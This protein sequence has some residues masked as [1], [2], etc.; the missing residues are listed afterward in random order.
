[1][2]STLIYMTAY[3]ARGFELI[4][5]ILIH[6]AI[7]LFIKSWF[8]S[9]VFSIATTVTIA[10]AV[11]I[12]L[13]TD[14]LNKYNSTLFIIFLYGVIVFILWYLPYQFDSL[15]N[16]NKRLQEKLKKSEKYAIEEKLIYTYQEFKDLSNYL[17]S[18]C[19]LRGED[20]Y[21]FLF[22]IE[23]KEALTFK[24]LDRM[25]AKA[26]STLARKGIDITGKISNGKY[27]MFVQKINEIDEC[28]LVE[29]FY[30]TLSKL[31]VAT[32]TI[33][34]KILS[35]HYSEVDEGFFR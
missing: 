33:S 5:F 35:K 23:D 4:I 29:E 3:F 20:G 32:N 26:L 6:A 15:L 11:F 2:F 8:F 27:V 9:L 1:M 13:Y 7:F 21:Y 14:P 17:E 19:R 34:I 10:L 30:V 18:S 24:S 12:A 22:E 28:Q 31:G 16:D 25:V